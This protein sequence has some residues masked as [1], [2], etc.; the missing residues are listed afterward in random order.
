LDNLLQGFPDVSR[1]QAVAYLEMAREAAEGTSVE[2]GCIGRPSLATGATA[3]VGRG[4][5]EEENANGGMDVE[6]TKTEID[7][8]LFEAVH[9]L[10]AEQGREDSEVL[11]DAVSYYL[12]F[13]SGLSGHEVVSEER[14]ALARE[15]LLEL[16]GAGGLG[17][18][19]AQALAEKAVR[20][21][22]TE[23]PERG[24][25]RPAP[26]PEEMRTRLGVRASGK[27]GGPS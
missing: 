23:A 13:L 12:L 5:M 16:V 1:E 27:P 24:E 8:T 9:K 25:E 20:R 15:R 6:R 10:A 19:E 11:E 14:R 22:R 2:D 4:S 18:E 3:T 7:S 17:D 21:A 26:S